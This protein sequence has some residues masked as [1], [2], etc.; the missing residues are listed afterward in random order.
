MRCPL[1]CRYFHR[2]LPFKC[3][4]L[5]LVL[6]QVLV[7]NTHFN[8]N[9]CTFSGSSFS[10]QARFSLCAS[11]KLN[12]SFASLYD[13][14]VRP[15]SMPVALARIVLILWDLNSLIIGLIVFEIFW[16]LVMTSFWRHLLCSTSSRL[17]L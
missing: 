6:F 1:N 13:L 2:H 5:L 16:W 11:T 4:L 17:L 15:A 10:D 12:I 14:G 7:E 3:F 8:F 9:I